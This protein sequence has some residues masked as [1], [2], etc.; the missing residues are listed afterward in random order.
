MD[1]LRP[2]SSL[3]RFD[4]PNPSLPLYLPTSLELEL[5]A[6][7]ATAALA[8]TWLVIAYALFS[9]A[10]PLAGAFSANPT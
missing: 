6:R 7:W 5:A 4:V 1:F 9:L 10:E 3:C 2:N 8:R